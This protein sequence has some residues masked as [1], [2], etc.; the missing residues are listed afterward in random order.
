MRGGAIRKIFICLWFYNILHEYQGGMVQRLDATLDKAFCRYLLCFRSLCYLGERFI[1]IVGGACAL[2]AASG[3]CCCCDLQC[4][5]AV[6]Y[7]GKGI[8]SPCVV[9]PLSLLAQGREFVWA[10][11]SVFWKLVLALHCT[12]IKTRFRNWQPPK[13]GSG[14]FRSLGQQKFNNSKRKLRIYAWWCHP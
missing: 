4:F 2:F 14:R 7:L 5:R 6:C 1:V 8:L 3:R 13:S 10:W 9:L 12:F 11:K